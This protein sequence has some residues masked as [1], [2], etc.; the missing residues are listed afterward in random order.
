M[1]CFPNV[2][3]LYINSR[4]FN[5]DFYVTEGGLCE[6]KG[7]FILRGRHHMKPK[8]KQNQKTQS[9]QYAHADMMSVSISLD[10]Q[11]FWFCLKSPTEIVQDSS[12]SRFDFHHVFL[13]SFFHF[14][15]E[16]MS[17]LGCQTPR[18]WSSCAAGLRGTGESHPFDRP[19]S[20]WNQRFSKKTLET[21]LDYALTITYLYTVCLCSLLLI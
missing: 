5:F 9:D 12:S 4:F 15:I 11:L 18:S 13:P 7:T 14:A 2:K 17:C 20:C 10:D 6:R 21:Q 19:S 16:P 8:R 3:K 1:L